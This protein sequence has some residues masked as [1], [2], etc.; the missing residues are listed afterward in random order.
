MAWSDVVL[1]IALSGIVG[2]PILGF[3][4]YW[5]AELLGLRVEARKRRLTV[6]EAEEVRAQIAR[7][8]AQI[9]ELQS[10]GE[11]LASVE[12]QFV[13]LERLVGRRAENPHLPLEAPDSNQA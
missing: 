2:L 8:Q 9:D 12:E 1:I 3:T 13:F 5:I 10:T 6:A 7:M 4:L 11:R